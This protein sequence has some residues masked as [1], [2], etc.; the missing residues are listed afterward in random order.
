[1]EIVVLFVF[2]V[3]ALLGWGCGVVHDRFFSY[4]PLKSELDIPAHGDHTIQEEMSLK[5]IIRTNS[6]K[7]FDAI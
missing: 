7:G 5:D 2:L 1:M 3:I 4:H 6:T